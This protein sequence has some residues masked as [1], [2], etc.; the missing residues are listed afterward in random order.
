MPAVNY[1]LMRQQMLSKTTG[2]VGQVIYWGLPLDAKNQTLTPNPDAFYF[3]VFFN[4]E[5]IGTCVT[6]WT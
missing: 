2:K 6:L 3:M 1:D 5:R 4:L